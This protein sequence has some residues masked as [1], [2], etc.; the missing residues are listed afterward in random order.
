MSQRDVWVDPCGAACWKVGS[1]Q[2]RRNER[3]RDQCNNQG[4]ESRKHPDEHRPE[5]HAQ[6]DATRQPNR[7]P[8]DNGTRAIQQYHLNQPLRI[9]TKGHTDAEFA[10]A[11]EDEFGQH[12]E[13]TC[14]SQ[15]EREPA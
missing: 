8:G 3:D 4:I 13:Q 6:Y 14:H 2:R 11:A 1:K 7:K 15:K 12:A 10:S 9:R 5:R